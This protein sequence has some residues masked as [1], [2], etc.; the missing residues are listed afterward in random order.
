MEVRAYI[1]DMDGTLLNTLPTI[2]YH[3]NL[4]LKHFGFHE[5]TLEECRDLCRLSIGHFYHKLLALGGCPTEKIDALQPKI[6]DL[7]CNRYLENP[8]F[9]T[10]PFDGIISTLK[11]LKER[12]IV[13]GILT[14]K[15]HAIAV[16]LCA[17]F[18]DDL[19]DICIG[20]TPDTISKPH[21]E[22]MD[23]VFSSLHFK[24]SDI[25]YIGDT[26]IDMQTA[27]NTGV[28]AAAATWGFQSIDTLLSYQPDFIL[29]SPEELLTL[30]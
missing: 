8:S 25:L 18:F 24:P 14:N 19:I 7:D 30:L 11:T 10:E 27:R 26:D 2:H 5:I 9:L 3:C 4:S 23:G 16:S 22:C 17:H 12:G 1:W 29:S 15:P 6:R 20:Q 28:L 13:N 21:K